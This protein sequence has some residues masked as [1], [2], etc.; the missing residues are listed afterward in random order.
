MGKAERR[1]ILSVSASDC[2][3]QTFAAG[4]KGGQRQNTCNT[5]VRLIHHPSGARGEARDE[6]QQI[7][8][9]RLA[10]MRLIKSPKFETWLKRVTGQ[11]AV[12]ESETQ[13]AP[14]SD[15]DLK[16]EAKKNGRWTQVHESELAA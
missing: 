5:G 15:S 4:G 13:L 3:M 1:R 12:I 11:L 10:F 8:N 6:R 16:I 9:K 14:I 7:Q 2:E